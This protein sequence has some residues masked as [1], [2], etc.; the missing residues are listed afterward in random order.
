MLRNPVGVGFPM[1]ECRNPARLNQQRQALLAAKRRGSETLTAL[2]EE[3]IL[4]A[5]PRALQSLV[6]TVAAEHTPAQGN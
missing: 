4:A 1:N 2:S 3:D 5:G 6:D